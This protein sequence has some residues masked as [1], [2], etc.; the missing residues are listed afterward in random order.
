MAPD[1]RNGTGKEKKNKKE[2]KKVKGSK[3]YFILICKELF[4]FVNSK[5]V[6]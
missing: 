6:S 5:L 3:I 1:P 4:F 2:K